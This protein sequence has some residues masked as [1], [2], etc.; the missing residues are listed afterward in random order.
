MEW[1]K[2]LFSFSSFPAFFPTTFSW[3]DGWIKFIFSL[4]P[5]T[6][7]TADELELEEDSPNEHKKPKLG[8][9]K[10]HAEDIVW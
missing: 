6:E 8:S 5:G 1:L 7:K 10:W 9:W 4:L 3:L 2:A